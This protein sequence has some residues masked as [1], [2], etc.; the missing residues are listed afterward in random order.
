MP[1]RPDVRNSI[2]SL[3]YRHM[4][5]FL[6]FALGPNRNDAPTRKPAR[7]LVFATDLDGMLFDAPANVFDEAS[8]AVRILEDNGIPLVV[9]SRRTRVEVES[10]QQKLGFTAPFISESGG[11]LFVPPAYFPQWPVETYRKLAYHVIE[12]GPPHHVVAKAL[13]AVSRRVDV[14]VVAFSDMSIEEVASACSLTLTEARLAKLHEYGETFRLV[15]EDRAEESRLCAALNRTGLNCLRLGR[16]HYVTGVQDCGRSVQLLRSLYEH[17][18]NVVAFGFTLRADETWVLGEV[19]IP[20]NLCAGITGS[21][22]WTDAV[23]RVLASTNADEARSL[24]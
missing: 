1:N 7:T 11:G 4:T 21:P 18:G 13:H 24:T 22:K 6:N 10:L 19:D 5:H 16:F 17:T 9:C 3:N 20:I 15:R 2:G 14:E 8:G 12:F 23:A